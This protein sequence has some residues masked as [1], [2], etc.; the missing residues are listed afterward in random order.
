MKR[1]IARLLA[2]RPRKPTSFLPGAG[3]SNVVDGK[4]YHSSSAS[5]IIPFIPQ[6]PLNLF[7]VDTP[8]EGQARLDI[9]TV[10]R[11]TL[12]I[13][14]EW[15]DETGCFPQQ[16]NEDLL[17][18]YAVYA[19][20]LADVPTQLYSSVPVGE[21][22]GLA[23][24]YVYAVKGQRKVLRQFKKGQ[25][26]LASLMLDFAGTIACRETLQVAFDL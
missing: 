17:R 19:R 22:E 1:L 16:A 2:L 24:Q 18:L 10:G 3:R 15:S 12:D 11:R 8:D 4:A 7:G 23:R 9:L 14:D 20:S 5:Q 21:V 6:Y 26:S 25:I 13:L